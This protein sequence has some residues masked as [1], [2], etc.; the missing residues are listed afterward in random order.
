V[1]TGVI[2]VTSSFWLVFVMPMG[3]GRGDGFFSGGFEDVLGNPPRSFN[4]IDCKSPD[5]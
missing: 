5:N 4:C 1:G 3:R 2:S